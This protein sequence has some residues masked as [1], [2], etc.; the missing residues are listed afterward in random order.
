MAGQVILDKVV[1]TLF[2]RLHFL[3]DEINSLYGLINERGGDAIP[4]KNKVERLFQRTR[5]LKDPRDSFS[6]RMTVEVRERSHIEVTIS[7][8]SLPIG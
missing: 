2:E 5:N 3:K 6:D 7:L 1:L 8:M 4:L